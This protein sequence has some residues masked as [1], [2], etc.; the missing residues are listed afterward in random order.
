MAEQIPRFLGTLPTIQQREEI[1]HV[2]I[3]GDGP[4]GKLDRKTTQK[5]NE[6]DKIRDNSKVGSGFGKNISNWVGREMAYPSNVLSFATE[7]SNVNHS[8]L[9]PSNF[10]EWFIRLFTKEG[11]VVLDPFSGSG[12]NGVAAHELKRNYILIDTILEYNETSR[13]RIQNGNYRGGFGNG[14]KTIAGDCSSEI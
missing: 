1:Q 9:F 10:R 4:Y 12:S 7:C 14:Q 5:T 6:T 13:K 2:P 11:D 8:E 3:I